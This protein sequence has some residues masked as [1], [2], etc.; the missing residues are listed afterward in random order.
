M[1][2]AHD[3]WVGDASCLGEQDE[4]EDSADEGECATDAECG[5]IILPEGFVDWT[6]GERDDE[7]NK[8]QQ[9]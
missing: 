5:R 4:R 1:P 9:V 2:T 7:L 6:G 8:E 3:G